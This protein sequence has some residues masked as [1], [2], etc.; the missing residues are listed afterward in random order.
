MG[1]HVPGSSDLAQLQV[2]DGAGVNEGL[3]DDREAGVDVVCLVNVEDKLGVFQDVHPEP[4]RKAVGWGQQRRCEPMLWVGH[5]RKWPPRVLRGQ[6]QPGPEGSPSRLVEPVTRQN[7]G[8][9]I[10][11]WG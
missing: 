11:R 2:R 10:H 7:L 4:E 8:V 1:Q 3:C 9:P 5:Q 6:R